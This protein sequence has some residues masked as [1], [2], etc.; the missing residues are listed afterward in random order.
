MIIDFP[1]I[2]DHEIVEMK[3]EDFPNGILIH[4]V[5]EEKIGDFFVI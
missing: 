3:I 1:L 4:K 5:E 2:I